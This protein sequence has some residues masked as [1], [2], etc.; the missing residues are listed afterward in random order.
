M[1]QR[2]S[3]PLLTVYIIIIV[4]LLYMLTVPME[5]DR[6]GIEN[7]VRSI[8]Q[9]KIEIALIKKAEARK[10]IVF[11]EWQSS[12]NDYFGIATVKKSVVGWQFTGGSTTETPEKYLIG[13]SYNHIESEFADYKGILYGIIKDSTITHIIIH[14]QDG[15]E[16]DANIA[17][18]S[19]G[20]RFW[21]MLSQR[22]DLASAIVEAYDGNGKL[23]QRIPSSP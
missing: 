23:L 4:F 17:M 9:P 14:E 16:L 5:N 15:N 2:T 6:R 18:Y 7:A 19:D 11:Y 21:Y 1:L 20:K 22:D 8:E 13:W 3:K 10:A 12:E